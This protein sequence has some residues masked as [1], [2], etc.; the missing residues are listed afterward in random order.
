MKKEEGGNDRTGIT[1]IFGLLLMVGTLGMLMFGGITA[2]VHC[3]AGSEC[4]AGGGNQSL[5]VII[6]AVSLEMYEQYRRSEKLHDEFGMNEALA[7]RD[8]VRLDMGTP[9]RIL[10]SDCCQGVF[11]SARGNRSFIMRRARVLA[12]ANVG[13]ALWLEDSDLSTADEN[14]AHKTH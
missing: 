7:K 11:D 13:M 6:G 8:V 2:M 5:P 9:V 10:G 1:T 14:A 12:G 4:M 3:D